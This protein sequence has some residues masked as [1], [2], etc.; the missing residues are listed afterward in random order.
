[1]AAA[2]IVVSLLIAGFGSVNGDCAEDLVKYNVFLEDSFGD[3]WNGNDMRITECD[4]NQ[5]AVDPNHDPITLDDGYS[6]ETYV[7]FPADLELYNLEVGGAYWGNEISWRIVLDEGENATNETIWHEGGSPYYYS[8][9]PTPSPTACPNLKYTIEMSDSYGDGWE[10]NEIAVLDCDGNLIKNGITLEDG[11]YAT[12]EI[13]LDTTYFTVACGGGS[14]A[15]EVSWDVLDPN[16]EMIMAGGVG[17]E[18]TCQTCKQAGG[19]NL[20]VYV[21]DAHLPDG[22]EWYDPEAD[23]YVKIKANGISETTHTKNNNNDPKW[24]QY[25]YYGCVHLDDY[26]DVKVY[27]EDDILGG[28]DDLLVYNRWEDWINW[29]VGQLKRLNDTSSSNNDAYHKEYYVEIAYFIGNDFTLSPTRQPVPHPTR[30]PTLLPSLKPTESPIVAPT[31]APYTP[32]SPAPPT[33]G[34]PVPSPTKS[35]TP[36]TPPTHKTKSP[37]HMP[38][39]GPGGGHHSDDDDDGSGAI[40]GGVFA[41]LIGIALLCALIY[42][43]RKNGLPMFIRDKLVDLDVGMSSYSPMGA[44]NQGSVRPPGGNNMTFNKLR[45]EVQT[46][47]RPTTSPGGYV[48]PV[49][50]TADNDDDDEEEVPIG[51]IGRNSASV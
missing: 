11:S 48:P 22:G 26:I 33:P 34:P 7:C 5:T 38:T 16:N 14:F 4:A 49:L 28:S 42:Y 19:V 10:G 47:Q 1:M 12:Q 31:P 37:T 25:L 8:T 32:P 15:T 2:V 13:C 24:K 23:A 6:Q 3:G 41:A 51:G 20:T 46:P 40:I 35:P 21:Y 30:A 45:E 44:A 18:T 29:P 36:P 43:L 27:D 50:A 39:K 9:C 17:Q